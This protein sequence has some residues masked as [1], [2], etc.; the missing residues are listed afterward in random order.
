M[1]WIVSSF[2]FFVLVSVKGSI[3]VLGGTGTANSY[4]S[5]VELITVDGPNCR[6]PNLTQGRYGA[7][8]EN[9]NGTIFVC[10]GFTEEDPFN[11][12]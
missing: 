5:S 10:G 2:L 8:A 12:G 9:L 4:L 7:V 11:A 6:F 3:L 1:V